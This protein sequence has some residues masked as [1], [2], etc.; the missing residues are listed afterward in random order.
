MSGSLH[1]NRK[2]LF[3]TLLCLP[4]NKSPGC[5]TLSSPS[6]YSLFSEMHSAEEADW[7]CEGRGC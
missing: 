7:R 1:R 3:Q 4:S 2:D 6:L 5:G